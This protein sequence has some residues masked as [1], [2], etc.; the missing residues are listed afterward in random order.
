MFIIK[1]SKWLK[2]E[3][4]ISGSKNA[5]LPIVAANYLIGN[6]IKLNN[7]PNISDIKTLQTIGDQDLSKW[8]LASELAQKIRAS[9]LLIPA[10]LKK[11]GKITFCQPGGCNIGK[12]PLDTFDS[13]LY[14]AWV[15]IKD[16]WEWKQYIQARKPKKHIMLTEFSVTATEGLITYLAFLDDIDYEIKISQVAIEPHVVNLIDFLTLAGADIKMTHNHQIIVKPSKIDIKWDSFDIIGDYIEAGTYFGLGAV[17][18]N[19][20]IVLKW[21]N[22]EHLESVFVIADKIGIN[23]EIWDNQIKVNSFNKDNYKACKIQTMIFPWFPTDL[24]PIFGTILTQ[25]QGIGKIFETLFEG[26]FS[27]LTELENMG[28]KVEILNPHQAI[29]IWAS[30]LSG[31]YVATK[32][33]RAGWA[34]LIA[35]TIA[36]WTTYIT[37]EDIIERWYADIENKLKSVGV[38]IT[39]S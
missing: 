3:I 7:L 30:K 13:A 2:W 31:S 12:R 15:D 29:I 25:S 8:T 17:A 10:W 5:G 23:Y 6:K 32:D 26:R 14:Q 36:E 22:P 27:Y 9:I 18:E 11:F 19:S 16:E 4:Q 24:Q 39:K 1:N 34:L 20:E 33:L 37:N 35:W 38:D 21:I 28:A